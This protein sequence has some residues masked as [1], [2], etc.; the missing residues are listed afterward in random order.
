MNIVSDW[1][2]QVELGQKPSQADLLDHL[3]IIHQNNTGFTE[4]IANNCKDKFGNNSYDILLDVLDKKKHLNVLDIACGSGFLLDLC[5]KKFNGELLL[6]GIDM[7]FAELELARKKLSNTKIKLHQ[8]MA[9]ELD[10]L[11]DNSFE[12]ILCHWALPLMDPIEPVFST[13]K[14]ILKNKGVFA[15]IIDGDLNAAPEYSDIHNIIYKYVQQE[16]PNYG[17]IELGDIR[18]RNSMDLHNLALK[19]FSNSDV[20]IT[21]HLLYFRDSPK[22]LAREVSGFFYASFVLS[23][24]GHNKMLIEL[25][26]YFLSRLDTDISCFTMPVNR[27]VVNFK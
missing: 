21:S 8:S 1:T 13:V 9:Q 19:K 6:T 26:S 20:N 3:K 15:A 18:V 2:R 7:S 17:S 24:E 4:K 22:N 27:L 11:K 14:R 5:N 10:F 23:K 16:Y 25:E 12:V